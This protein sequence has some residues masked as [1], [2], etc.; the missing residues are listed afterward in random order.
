MEDISRAV[1]LVAGVTQPEEKGMR[2][3]FGLSFKGLYQGDKKM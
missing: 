1:G 2:L 3:G